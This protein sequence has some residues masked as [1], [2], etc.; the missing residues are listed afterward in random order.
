MHMENN[1][2][3]QTMDTV[4]NVKAKTK[5]NFK[6]RRDKSTHCKHKRLDVRVVKVNEVRV[7]LCHSLHIF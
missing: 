4:M 5:H 3:E 2:F 6:S 7:K 1:V